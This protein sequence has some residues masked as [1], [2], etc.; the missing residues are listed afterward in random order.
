MEHSTTEI[1]EF[2]GRADATK[3]NFEILSGYDI[4]TKS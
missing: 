4:G 3:S 2:S 1:Y